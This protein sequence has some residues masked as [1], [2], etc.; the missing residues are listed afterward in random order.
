MILIFDLFGTLVQVISMDFNRGLRSLWEEHYKD[1]CTFEEIKAY[2]EELY[3]LML[4]KNRKGLEFPFVSEELPLYAKRFGGDTIRMSAEEEAGFLMLCNE[5]RIFEG[6]P[7][8][9]GS[10]RKENIPMYVLSNSGFTDGALSIM[11]DSLG[12]G[13]YFEKVWSSADFGRIKPDKDFF[14]MAVLGIQEKYPKIT[15]DDI[16]YTGDTYFTDIAGAHNAG[17]RCVWIDPEDEPDEYGYAAYQI[18][19]ITGLSA[20]VMSLIRK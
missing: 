20:K 11:L 4:E 8:M 9:L 14:E 7:E 17:I 15:K 2:G 19:D 13:H 5:V 16:I 18:K 3:G 1:I 6:L 10:F 12:I